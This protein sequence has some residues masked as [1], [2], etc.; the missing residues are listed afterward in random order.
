LIGTYGNLIKSIGDVPEED[1]RRTF[2]LGIGLILI[3]DRKGVDSVIAALKRK[4]E[5]PFVIG[6][7]M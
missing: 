2:N 1:M 4:R 3:V 6:K 5:N 7:I